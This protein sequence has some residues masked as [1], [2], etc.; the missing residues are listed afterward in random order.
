MDKQAVNWVAKII[1]VIYVHYKLLLDME[2]IVLRG[3]I[4]GNILY[5]F[6]LLK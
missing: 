6:V 2:I 3:Y 5:L 4:Y 1:T